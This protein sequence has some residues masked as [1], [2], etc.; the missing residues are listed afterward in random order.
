MSASKEPPLHA[1]GL[2]TIRSD[3][4]RSLRLIIDTIPALAWSARPDGSAEFFS[5]Y[6]LDYIGF[7]ADQANGL[8]WTAAVHPDDLGSLLATWQRLMAAGAA[9][10]T[11]A[12]LRKHDGEYRWFLFRANPLRNDAGAIVKWYGVNTDIEARKR[13]EDALR[14]SERQF[15]LLV[16]TIPALVWRGTADGDLD[17]LNQR[18]VAYLGHTAQ[19]LSGGGWLDVIH[20]DHRD[21]TVRRWMQ[22]VTTGT[23]Y[24]D[25][26]QLRRAD[27]E[28]RWTQSVG[29][30]FRDTEGRITQWYG[31][32]VDIHDRKRAEESLR[33]SEASLAQAQRLTLTGSI[34]WDVA[35]GEIV[36]SDETFRIMG[37]PTTMRPSVELVLSRVHPDDV[38]QVREVIERAAVDDASVDSEYRLLMPDGAVKHVHV[39]LQ[40]VGRQ[41]GRR[42]FVGAVT[43]ITARRQPEIALD[44]A[45]A[46]LAHVARLATL[47]TLTAS[48]THEVS[49]PLSG[50]ITNAATCLRMLDA[51][52]PNVDG[53]RETARRTIRDGNRAA[54]VISGLRAM[55][56]RKESVIESVDLNAATRE[57]MALTTDELQRN[58][59]RLRSDLAADLPTIAGDRVQ[60]QQVVLNLVRNA[61][62]A[63]TGLDDRPR[64]VLI[65]TSRRD[66]DVVLSVRDSGPGFDP[67]LRDQIFDA[68]YTTKVDGMG[69]GL[70][71][72]RSIVEGHHGRL[73]ADLNDGPGAT[74]SFS[75]P[76]QTS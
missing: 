72:S 59:I 45:R 1:S 24:D 5:Q 66:G 37:V 23:S 70:S 36:W 56:T 46:E 25:V 19:N 61:A 26:Y 42:E 71:V 58:R 51:R 8:G 14:E 9:G 28:Y 74:F 41:P 2:P 10:E 60:L 53:A 20:P 15:R 62:D 64:H 76:A 21:A 4:E 31:V 32:I 75:I 38:V 27:G 16:E 49:Q 30:P 12:R 39:V 6:Y 3:E 18:A 67:R 43:D 34:W 55:F 63:M 65:T 69:I 17:Y 7:S 68:F 40:P 48:I 22:S 52:P 47:S 13:A 57:V 35:T 29:E 44:Q 54:E 50:I 11:E 73:W 33:R